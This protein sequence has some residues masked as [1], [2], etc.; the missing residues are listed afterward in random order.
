MTERSKIRLGLLSS[1]LIL[2]DDDDDDDDMN[3]QIKYIISPIFIN[4]GIHMT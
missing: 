3:M 2:V 4:T 1:G